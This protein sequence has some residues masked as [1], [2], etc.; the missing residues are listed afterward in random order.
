MKRF[1]ILIAFL[2]LTVPALIEAATPDRYERFLDPSLKVLYRAQQGTESASR[3]QAEV[4]LTRLH[5]P[6]SLRTKG[7]GTD[8]LNLVIKFRGDQSRLMESGFSVDSCVGP[9]CTGTASGGSA[10]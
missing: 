10:S 9:I 3:T 5:A 2:S 7:A 6:E 4:L 1:P 8:R